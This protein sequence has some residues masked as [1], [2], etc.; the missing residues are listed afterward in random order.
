LIVFDVDQ[1]DRETG[2][3][4]I[5]DLGANCYPSEPIL[6]PGKD[7]PEQGWILTVVFDGNTNS[8]EVRIYQSDR[9]VSLPLV[10][11]PGFSNADNFSFTGRNW[12][13]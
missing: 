1:N 8:S 11:M 3:M 10:F 6:V 7:H 12:A 13:V 2:E 4:A 9:L 5:A